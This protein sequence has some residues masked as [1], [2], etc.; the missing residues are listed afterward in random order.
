MNGT[1]EANSIVAD[2]LTDTFVARDEWP[3]AAHKSKAE[4]VAEFLEEERHQ[5]YGEGVKATATGG[6]PSYMS[7]NED[8]QSR[9]RKFLARHTYLKGALGAVSTEQLVNFSKPK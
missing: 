4:L 8:Q 6:L 2:T 3:N 9:L 5:A 7:M 1:H